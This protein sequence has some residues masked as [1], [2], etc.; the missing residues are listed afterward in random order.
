MTNSYIHP[1]TFRKLKPT[2]IY[3]LFRSGFLPDDPT[4]YLS[5]NE[6]IETVTREILQELHL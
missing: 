3:Q 4:I 6:E 5:I 1:L 2:E